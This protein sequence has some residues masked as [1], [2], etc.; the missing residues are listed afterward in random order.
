MGAMGLHNDA[1]REKTKSAMS[2][3]S[4]KASDSSKI[5]RKTVDMASR[6]SQSGWVHLLLVLSVEI[7]D[8]IKRPSWDDCPCGRGEAEA[9]TLCVGAG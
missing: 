6:R 5:S 8:D 9:V 3:A 7:I 4:S 1:A 2:Q